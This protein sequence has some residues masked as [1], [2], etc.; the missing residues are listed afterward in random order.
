MYT[1]IT[2]FHHSQQDQTVSIIQ[3]EYHIEMN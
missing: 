1:L 2:A 3:Q